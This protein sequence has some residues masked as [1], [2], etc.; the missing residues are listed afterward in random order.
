MTKR[1]FIALAAINATI[2]NPTTRA[3]V[4]SEQADYFA[5]INPNFDRERFLAASGV[6]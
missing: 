3:F 4:A 5:T 6:K 1:H 2:S